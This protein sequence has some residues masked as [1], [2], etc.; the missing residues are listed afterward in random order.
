VHTGVDEQP[1]VHGMRVAGQHRQ[2]DRTRLGVRPYQA[3]TL[4]EA[5]VGDRPGDLRF[6]F[7]Q[8]VLVRPHRHPAGPDQHRVARAQLDLLRLQRAAELVDRNRVRTAEPLHAEMTGYVDHHASA[9][10]RRHLGT[11]VLGRAE[12]TEGVVGPHTAVP[13]VVRGDTDVG[14]RVHMG[15][16]VVGADHHLGDQPDVAVL[17]S[18][19]SH[20]WSPPVRMPRGLR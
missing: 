19:F 9:D 20:S 1:F 16:A 5:V 6:G 13:V 2:H 10:E 11:V 18:G 12:V 3:D 14:E 7:G 15:A 17:T 4:V 8:L